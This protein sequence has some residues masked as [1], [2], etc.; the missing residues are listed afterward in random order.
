MLL[1]VE[2]LYGYEE[3]TVEVGGSSGSLVRRAEGYVP[4]L[5]AQRDLCPTIVWRSESAGMEPDSTPSDRGA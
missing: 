4:P 2:A 3:A 5:V 1:P